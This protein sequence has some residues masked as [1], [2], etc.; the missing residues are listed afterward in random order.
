MGDRFWRAAEEAAGTEYGK[1]NAAAYARR[2]RLARTA[3]WAFVGLF[4]LYVF[5]RTYADRLY[6]YAMYGAGALFVFIGVCTFTYIAYRVYR[7]RT[8]VGRT[9]KRPAAYVRD[10]EI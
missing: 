3:G 4:A 1:A 8:Y 10:D 2:A 9:Y 6:V 5:A 7:S